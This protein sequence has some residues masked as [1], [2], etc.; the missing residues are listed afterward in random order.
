MYCFISNV[1]PSIGIYIY[2]IWLI[3]Y[4]IV[5]TSGF[6]VHSWV[7]V[8]RGKFPI[9]TSSNTCLCI[10]RIRKWQGREP[11][12]RMF[13][14]TVMYNILKQ[15]KGKT[16]LLNTTFNNISVTWCSV[17]LVEETGGPGENHRPVASH[18]QTLSHN[19]I[20]LPLTTTY[21]ISAHHHWCCEFETWSG[22]GV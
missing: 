6:S 17:L 18:W 12:W 21:A 22:G 14:L 5:V 19:V 4:T 11:Q 9:M 8:S 15:G 20:H 3:K 13:S 10:Q 2:L 7:A 1:Y 16:V